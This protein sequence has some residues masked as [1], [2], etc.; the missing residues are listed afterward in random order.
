MLS[1]L[2]SS[3]TPD[4]IS[5][6]LAASTAS[7]SVKVS[8]VCCASCGV[9]RLPPWC[10]PRSTTPWRAWTLA[11]IGLLP[12]LALAQRHPWIVLERGRC[13]PCHDAF[14]AAPTAAALAAL[15]P[16]AVPVAPFPPLPL[17]AGQLAAH[18]VAGLAERP[19][20]VPLRAS[21]VH[22]SERTALR[23]AGTWPRPWRCR[24]SF[25]VL[26]LPGAPPLA[27]W[28]VLF[29]GGEAAPWVG[30]VQPVGAL[31]P[32]LDPVAQGDTGAHVPC[33]LQP[34]GRRGALF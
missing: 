33:L 2:S 34:Q 11:P 5:A 14:V 12:R 25:P 19:P 30:P 17:T 24:P 6:N 21:D 32:C 7:N 29:E 13:G 15:P 31:L 10:L 18:A 20:R 4:S 3:V 16:C 8:L 23:L 9:N 28:A 22:H 27:P 1:S 26:A